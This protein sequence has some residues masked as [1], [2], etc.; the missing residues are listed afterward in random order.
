MTSKKVN[1]RLYGSVSE[2]RAML[3]AHCKLE[4]NARIIK[5]YVFERFSGR[6]WYGLNNGKACIDALTDGYPEGE[7]AIARMRESIKGKLPHAVGVGRT[8]TRGY[9][10]DEL[11]IHAVNR[12]DL[13][14]A[15]TSRQRK[16]RRTLTNI[17]I[18]VDIGGNAATNASSLAWRGVAAA[19]LAEVMTKARYN[20]EIIAAWA[21]WGSID[22]WDGVNLNAC[23]I[24][25]FGAS[26]NLSIL[27][28]TVG[29]AGFFRT[30]GFAAIIRAADEMGLNA[31]SSLGH[32]SDAAESFPDDGKVMRIAVP[33]NISDAEM[34]KAW[35][36]ET[37]ELIESVKGVQ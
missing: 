30:L 35:L 2:M 17:R 34:A 24:K 33:G 11:D 6:T 20:T 14:N 19:T 3:D 27:A 25:P 28:A 5:E 21:T 36:K 15:W 10:G 31:N 7:T 9:Q 22:G 8:L 16:V 23:V 4:S 12:G 32:Y 18:L 26:L 1:F 13:G 37:V 29:L